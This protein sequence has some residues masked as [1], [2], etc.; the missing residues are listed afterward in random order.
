MAFNLFGDLA[1]DVGL[2]D[3]AVHT[4]W[5]ETP[6]TVSE[7]RFAHSPGR[8][9][10]AY[11]NSLRAWD[12]AFILDQPD[13]R[14]GILAV[15]V[16][17]YEWAKPEIPKPENRK[18]NLEV[19]ERSRVFR[20]G[21]YDVLLRRS[22]QCLLWLEHLLML[23]MLQHPSGTW[24]WGRFV[25]LYPAGNVDYAEA[26]SRYREL[27][28]DASTFGTTTLE[29]LLDASALPAPTTPLLR[30]RYLPE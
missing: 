16:N 21:V 15:D 3:R 4:W 22:P 19:A 5:P 20:P 30:E 6:G 27:L 13:G 29:E 18:R 17:Y 8:L 2:A 12:A 1:A 11:L 25:V 24:S 10:R 23:S 7:V 28:A 14:K 9:D 26:T